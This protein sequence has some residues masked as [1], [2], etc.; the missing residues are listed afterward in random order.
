M[1]YAILIAQG[2]I[3]IGAVIPFST[4]VPHLYPRMG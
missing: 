2:K 1:Y 4:N 3:E